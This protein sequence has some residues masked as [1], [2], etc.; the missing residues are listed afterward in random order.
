MAVNVKTLTAKQARTL[1]I[2]ILLK[3]EKERRKAGR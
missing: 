2:K 1:A 3:A